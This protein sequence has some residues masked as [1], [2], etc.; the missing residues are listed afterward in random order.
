MENTI[1]V[2][3]D[4]MTPGKDYTNLIAFLRTFCFWAKPLESVWLIKT[5]STAEQ[6]RNAVQNHIDKNDEL[7]VV[8][9][10]KKPAAWFNLGDKVSSWIKSYL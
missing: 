2:S 7:L 10:T 8:D 5:P 1:L 4:L 3:Y 6:I 9:V